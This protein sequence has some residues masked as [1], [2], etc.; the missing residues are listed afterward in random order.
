VVVRKVSDNEKESEFMNNPQRS[1]RSVPRMV[2]IL[3]I[4][5]FSGQMFWFQYFLPPS[6]QVQPLRSPPSVST[7]RLLSLGDTIVTAKI[8]MLWLQSFDNQNGQFLSYQQLNYT[9]LRQWLE[10]IIQLDPRS[11][12]PLLV[13]S[14]VY[15]N[16]TDPVKMT[17]MLELVYEQFL[18]EPN[19][20]WPWL[21]QATLL[22]KH[23]LKNLPLALKYARSIAKHA[24]PGMTKIPT[25]AR[26]M[27]LFILEDLGEFEQAQLI[28][29][30]ML[31]NEQ[32][33]DLNEIKFLNQKLQELAAKSMASEGK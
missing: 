33:T 12:Y 22:A 30:G 11:Q 24:T 32:V 6:A 2:I 19:S 5:S 13:A 27:Q 23:R 31:T 4:A 21:A 8:L 16:V 25:W 10:R 1:L 26:E 15:S 29:G 17:Q 14:H 28:I 18:L 7:L 9:A 3:L 20:R